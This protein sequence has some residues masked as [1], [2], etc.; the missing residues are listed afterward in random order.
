MMPH[1]IRRILMSA[2]AAP[3][4][5][6]LAACGGGGDEMAGLSGEVIEKIAPPAGKSWSEVVEKTA[7]GGYRMGN[8]EAPIK[9]IEYASLTCPHCAHFSEEASAELRDNFVD[10]G[11]VSWEF[12][13]FV[14]NPIDLTMA[15][16]VRCG[17]PE[18]FFALTEQTFDNQEELISKWD[19]ATENQRN[20]VVGLP[21]KERYQYLA[22][23]MGLQEFYGARGI[24]A[25]QAN[26]CLTD[27][28]AIDALDRMGRQQA[29]E[30]DI[31]GTPGF[32]ING[33]T[34]NVNSW[35]EIKTKLETMGAR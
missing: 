26:A 13:N 23:L 14:L 27:V 35:Q 7:E 20:R 3:L 8:P 16:V 4:A 2:F 32:V 19:S 18:S 5:L 1:S 29:E 28:D 30:H 22:T 25:D 10:S 17:S 12:R 24:A 33:V 21:P 34:Q 9:L 6:A 11:R 15:A 31:S